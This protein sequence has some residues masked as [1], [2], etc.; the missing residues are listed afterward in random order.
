MS[1]LKYRLVFHKKV[2][3]LFNK[4]AANIRTTLG[5]EDNLIV[6]D[7]IKAL[8]PRD[9]F[10]SAAR[11]QCTHMEVEAVAKLNKDGGYTTGVR[12]YLAMPVNGIPLMGM[13]EDFTKVDGY[14]TDITKEEAIEFLRE[15]EREMLSFEGYVL[16]DTQPCKKLHYSNHLK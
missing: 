10:A 3:D 8:K 15:Y 11:M 1:D 6:S 14:P 5:L 12:S 7:R 13:V 4:C 16:A 9:E 2:A